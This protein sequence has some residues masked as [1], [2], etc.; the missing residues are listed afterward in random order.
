MAEPDAASEYLAHLDRSGVGP[1]AAGTSSGWDWGRELGAD[2]PTMLLDAPLRLPPAGARRAIDDFPSVADAIKPKPEL[3]QGLTDLQQRKADDTRRITGDAERALDENRARMQ[4]A[5]EATGVGPDDLKPFDA[6]KAKSQFTSPVEAFGSL[7][8]VFAIVASA[9]TRQPMLNS[10]NGLTGALTAIKKKDEDGYK[11]SFDEWK[12]NSDLAIKR[13]NIQQQQ[14]QNAIQMMN[15]DMAAATTKM[16]LAA[17][18]YGDDQ[19]LTLLQQYGMSKE[20]IE[21]MSARAKATHEIAKSSSEITQIGLRDELYKRD[22]RSQSED[23]KQRWAAFNAYFMPKSSPQQEVAERIFF[24]NPDMPALELAKKMQEAGVL[25]GRLGLGGGGN[26][27]LTADRQIAADVAKMREQWAAEGKSPEEIAG[28]AA[29]MTRKLKTQA[30]PA[31]GNRIDQLIGLREKAGLMAQQIDKVEGLLA[32]HK[33]LAGIG[34]TILRPAEAV[35]NIFGSNETDRAQFKRYISELQEWG[36]RVLTES[37]GR[38]L[39]AE[40]AKLQ[41][42]LP[43]LSA[44]DTTANVVRAYREIKPLIAKIQQQLDARIR[45][46][47]PAASGAGPAAEPGSRRPAWMDAPEVETPGRRSDAG[48]I[49]VASADDPFLKRLSPG[50]WGTPAQLYNEYKDGGL[51][52]EQARERVINSIMRGSPDLTREEAEEL[53]RSAPMSERRQSRVV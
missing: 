24:E 33:G 43:G 34:G 9:F 10:I 40:A 41:S 50:E 15:V 7:G 46:E 20:L 1:G 49:K 44:G 12:A 13:Q 6:E 21:L 19:A 23:I 14:Y 29:D 52:S 35:G 28:L 17:A 47:R 22:P 8:A 32:K 48:S 53:L 51:S 11:R 16:Q 4:R 42:I 3:V 2:E 27:N 45:G 36:A 38:P 26:T 37:T 25:P 30:A 31:S 18:R 39:S 5:Y